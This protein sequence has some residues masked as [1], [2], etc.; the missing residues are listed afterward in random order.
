MGETQLQPT[1]DNNRLY[2]EPKA[3]L[4][5]FEPYAVAATIYKMYGVTNPEV[6]TQGY[7]AINTGLFK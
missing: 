7:G 5:T 3:D 2:T 1:E 4:Y 6:L